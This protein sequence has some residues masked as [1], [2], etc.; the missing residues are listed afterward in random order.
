MIYASIEMQLISVTITLLLISCK[1]FDREHYLATDRLMNM[2]L[3]VNLCKD[4]CYIA[5][6][7]LEGHPSLEVL[8]SVVTCGKCSLGFPIIMIF[9]HYIRHSMDG[10]GR[11]PDVAETV[12]Y[13]ICAFAMML[14]AASIFR[15]VVFSCAGGVYRRGPA[16]A[17]NQLLGF[18]MLMLS[19][20]IIGQ[21]RKNI[22]AKDIK[23]MLL[24][25]VIPLV[26]SIVQIFLPPEPDISNI[27]ITLGML[28]V[29]VISHIDRG[30][31]L[32]AKEKE[33]TELQV[34][35]MISQIKPHFMYNTLA[36]IQGMCH[37]NAPDTEETII[38]FSEYIRGNLDAIGQM[39]LVTFS[40][41]LEHTRLYLSLE[42]KRFGD[43]LNVVYDIQETD[44]MLPVL[45]LQPIVE[46]AVKH[47]IMKK[48]NG[49][50]V[51]IRTEKVDEDYRIIVKDDGVGFDITSQKNDSRKH[52][53]ISNVETR[54][55]AIS[56]GTLSIVSYPGKGTSVTIILPGG[57]N[58][59]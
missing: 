23:A 55:L 31:M 24:Y 1:R 18:L 15:P 39:K 17:A 45:T 9:T 29:F 13:M 12:E 26:S 44:F 5:S 46:N 42:K 34:S 25:L 21:C 49:G 35:T 33:L 11:F 27:G 50:T 57:E 28:A 43:M 47:G 38:K 8:D 56:H 7:I 10:R 51:M 36:V 20:F 30:I 40:K 16:F 58:E 52:I 32:S 19:M 59:T 54:L 37:D 4:L 14:N 41:E 3:W 53:G 48:I 2:M 22:P 6:I